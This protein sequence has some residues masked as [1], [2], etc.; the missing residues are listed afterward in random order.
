[1]KSETLFISDL[2]LHPSRPMVTKNFL[3]FLENEALSASALYILGD[4][5]EVWAGDDDPCPHHKKVIEALAKFSRSKIP[6]YFMRGNRD[7]LIDKA[8]AK[9]AGCIL[10]P[11]PTVIELDGQKIL[12]MHGDS[13]CTDDRSH[14]RFRKFSQHPI[15]RQL[16]LLLPF[17]SR[18]KIASGIRKNSQKAGAEREKISLLAEGNH[19]SKNPYDVDQKAIEHALI[20]HQANCLIHGHT[21]KA[22][23]HEFTLAGTKRKRIV[24]GEWG[25]L[26]SVLVYAK[27][28]VELKAVPF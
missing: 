12:L 18:H 5:F 3:R 2:H 19:Q 23:I 15:I 14:Q 11:D 8:F 26:G 13:L 22:G 7:F 10:M 16:F 1:M 9:A 24:L 21:H 25:V 20:H 27:D 28:H 17:S 6:L 4:F